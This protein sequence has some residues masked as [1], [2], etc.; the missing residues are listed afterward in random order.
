MAGA[1]RPSREPRGLRGLRVYTSLDLRP[2]VSTSHPS[3][4]QI[5]YQTTLYL[6]AF[7]PTI[8]STVYL[9]PIFVWLH[10]VWTKRR[11]GEAADALPL[12][13][14]ESGERAVALAAFSLVSWVLVEI[15][16]AVRIHSLYD[17]PTV[18]LWA[19]LIIR[20]LLAGLIAA[21]AVFFAAEYICRRH[22]WP[23]LLAAT[24]IEGNPRLWKIRVCHRLLLL[25][26]AISFLP[27][28]AV[29]L[30]TF[31][32]MDR[33]DLPGDPL[34]LRVMLVIIFIASSAALGGAWLAWIVS[35]PWADP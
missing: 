28:S 10:R 18:G 6:V 3:Q 34:L 1:T 7:L 5:Y 31:I 30:I 24:R 19:H 17:R 2:Y 26:G 15:P 12:R 21:V 27:L 14:R 8:A 33:P 25:W 13:R 11:E 29:A 9:W 32:R 23:T 20:P 22:A 16:V 4:L 35:A